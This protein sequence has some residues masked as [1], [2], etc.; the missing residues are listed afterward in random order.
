V[1]KVRHIEIEIAVDPHSA[2][3]S[4]NIETD[5]NGDPLELLIRAEE[6]DEIACVICGRS[7]G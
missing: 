1:T 6:E 5:P 2:F 4:I 3:W 7:L